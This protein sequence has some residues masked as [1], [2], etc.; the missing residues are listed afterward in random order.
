MT[1]CKQSCETTIVPVVFDI[2]KFYIGIESYMKIDNRGM[3]NS[4]L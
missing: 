2:S 1:I 3:V 4:V